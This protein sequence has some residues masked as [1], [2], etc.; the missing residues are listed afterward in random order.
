MLCFADDLH[1]IQLLFLTPVII[2]WIVPYLPL[3]RR[4][5]YIECCTYYVNNSADYEYNPPFC[6]RWLENKTVTCK[7]FD[8][9]SNSLNHLAVFLKR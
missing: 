9:N 3:S 2:I 5:K 4:A 6:L 7:L 8:H 1:P